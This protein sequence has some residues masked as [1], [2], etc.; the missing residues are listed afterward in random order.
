LTAAILQIIAATTLLLRV[1]GQTLQTHH[2]HIAWGVFH[3]RWLQLFG[4]HQCASI[5]FNVIR[6]LSSAQTEA[7]RG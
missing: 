2:L 4:L 6:S 3:H 5:A 1:I 7:A